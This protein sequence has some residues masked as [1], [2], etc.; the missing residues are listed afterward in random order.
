VLQKF[1]FMIFVLSVIGDYPTYTRME[2]SL[3]SEKKC[4]VMNKEL[5]CRKTINCTKARSDEF[6]K[7][8]RECNWQNK[9]N[10][11]I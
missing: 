10:R 3:L 11:K 6:R 5:A 4:L 1:F 8:F 9:I 2:Q 7:L